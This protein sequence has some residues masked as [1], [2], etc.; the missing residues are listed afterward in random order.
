MSRTFKLTNKIDLSLA[1]DFEFWPWSLVTFT[2]DSA[3][4]LIQSHNFC[5][6]ISEKEYQGITAWSDPKNVISLSE[7]EKFVR[8]EPSLQP[9]GSKEVAI[10]H[11]ASMRSALALRQS[12]FKAELKPI[13]LDHANFN[14]WFSC[15]S[16]KNGSD[17]V[18][19]AV[20]AMSFP[21]NFEGFESAIGRTFQTSNLAFSLA[22]IEKV[23]S[24][25][26]EV[27]MGSEVVSLIDPTSQQ[28]LM[29]SSDFYHW[30]YRGRMTILPSKS[31]PLATGPSYKNIPNLK[32]HFYYARFEAI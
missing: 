28:E 16:A 24:S 14:C 5:V 30:D 25:K 17:I 21:S 29:L 31:N 1:S 8:I 23:K 11:L 2:M 22:E 10:Q 9:Q 19:N 20:L 26:Y 6:P 27:A 4:Y 13:P 3:R 32:S 7:L 15:S 12:I 18:E